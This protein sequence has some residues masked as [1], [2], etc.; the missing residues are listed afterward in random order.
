MT[1]RRPLLARL[2]TLLFVAVLALLVGLPVPAARAQ[3]DAFAALSAQVQAEAQK[4]EAHAQRKP[5]LEA[6]IDAHNEKAAAHDDS[7]NTLNEQTAAHSA[8]VGSLNQRIDAHNAEPH[9]FQIPQQ[10]AQAQ[11]Y[12]AEAAEL[13]SEKTQL[14]AE[15]SRLQ[16]EQTRLDNEGTQLDAEEQQ[17][18]AQVTAYNQEGAQLAAECQQLLQ[19]V[20][21]ALDSLAAD[22]QPAGPAP[23]GDQG[24]PPPVLGHPR[25]IAG[26]G[27]DPVSRVR[28]EEALDTYGEANGVTVDKRPVW[29]QL[30]SDSVAKLPPSAVTDLQITRTYDGLVR[31]PN[32]NYRA[33]TVPTTTKGIT[34]G[35]KGFDDAVK[36]GGQARATVDGRQIVIDEVVTVPGKPVTPRTTTCGD[37]CELVS[38]GTPTTAT[39]SPRKLLDD[40]KAL[41]DTV[42]VSRDRYVTVATGQLGGELVYAVNQ[43]GTNPAMRELATSLGYERVFAT[44]L[45][46]DV[47]TDAEQIL[48]N[49]IDEGDEVGDGIIATSRPACGADR[50]DCAGR[51][52]TYPNIQLW[53]QQRNR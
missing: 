29:A 20:A 30:T 34:P 8:K 19:R 49:A 7:V 46:R 47:D 41:H 15:A 17:E 37:D 10:A 13:N 26:D 48:F 36:A 39:V 45:N 38:G 1:I 44:D 25:Q 3:G 27:G 32:G 24:R 2:V 40:A 28:A 52:V 11:A 22:P 18:R 51:S 5:D 21:A 23:G 4:A 42:P 31:K 35:Q 33:L 6:Q 14:D 9:E 16:G 50:Q 53:D 43:N 12:D